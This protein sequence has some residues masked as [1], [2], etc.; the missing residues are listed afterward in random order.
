MSTQIKFKPG[1]YVINHYSGIIKR[2]LSIQYRPTHILP[3]PHYEVQYLNRD[4]LLRE[5]GYMTN[6]HSLPCAHVDAHFVLH[7]GVFYEQ[8]ARL[9]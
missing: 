3:L 7:D 6:I 8:L 9:T 2:I 5:H 4:E 1:D